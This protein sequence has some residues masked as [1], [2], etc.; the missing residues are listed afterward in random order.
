MA[1]WMVRAAS[2]RSGTNIMSLRSAQRAA[3]GEAPL[4]AGVLP[5]RL[6]AYTRPLMALRRQ[7]Y[8]RGVFLKGRNAGLSFCRYLGNLLRPL[9]GKAL[10]CTHYYIF[11]VRH[12][13]RG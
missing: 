9:K 6:P 3:A 13:A 4:L 12:Q 10:F 1:R 11:K 8:L 7:S 5:V 2:E